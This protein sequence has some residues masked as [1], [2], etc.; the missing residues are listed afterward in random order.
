LLTQLSKIGD[1]KVISRTSV[2]QYRTGTRNLREIG[3][4]LGV[5]TVLEGSVQRADNRVRI[6]ARLSDT[7]DIDSPII[8][9]MPSSSMNGPVANSVTARPI[10]TS[11]SV[12]Q[13]TTR[14]V[15]PYSLGGTASANGAIWAMRN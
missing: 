15:P 13:N 4:A 2:L 3:E 6:E 1:L 9:P 7:H 14:S 5:A 11:S 8:T 12:N 10:S